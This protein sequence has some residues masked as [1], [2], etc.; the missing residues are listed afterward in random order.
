MNSKPYIAIMAWDNGSVGQPDT[1]QVFETSE[2]AESAIHDFFLSYDF[3]LREGKPFDPNNCD[4]NRGFGFE[5]FSNFEV[6]N[7]KVVKFMHCGGDGPVAFVRQS[8]SNKT[9]KHVC[10]RDCEMRPEYDF[11]NAK[12]RHPEPEELLL[13]SEYAIKVTRGKLIELLQ[14]AGELPDDLSG[15]R[16][17]FDDGPTIEDLAYTSNGT[18]VTIYVYPPKD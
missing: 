14:H 3:E 10:G 13:I 15:L 6:K 4:D 2:E 5:V 1:L 17:K 16:V 18:L 11:T 7:D 9:K 12:R 8:R